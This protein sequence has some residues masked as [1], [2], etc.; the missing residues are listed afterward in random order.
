LASGGLARTLWLMKLAIAFC[1]AGL[2]L[3]IQIPCALADDSGGGA[4]SPSPASASPPPQAM[5][6]KWYGGQIVASD[7]LSVLVIATGAGFRS[8]QTG[9]VGFGIYA[10]GGPLIHGA[11]GRVGTAFASLA[12]RAG[13]LVGGA[14]LGGLIGTAAGGC[15]AASDDDSPIS[16]KDA[17]ALFGGLVGGGLGMIAASTID[18]VVLAKED[19]PATQNDAGSRPPSRGLS[20]APFV[21]P[22]SEARGTWGATFGVVGTF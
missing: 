10:L 4:P 19:V 14:I 12:L 2:G 5:S 15:G 17:G 7:V 9:G 11:H 22:R 21:A 13:G 6:T 16:C 20:L 3:F 1:A 18:A 8:V